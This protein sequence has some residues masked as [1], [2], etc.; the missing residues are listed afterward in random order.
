MSRVGVGRRRRL[1]EGAVGEVE[2]GC[3]RGGMEGG[4]E[5]LREEWGRE[6]GCGVGGVVSGGEG[7]E[8]GGEMGWARHESAERQA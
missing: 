4:M 8:R 3:E 2:G 7:M 5:D 1:R 6:G